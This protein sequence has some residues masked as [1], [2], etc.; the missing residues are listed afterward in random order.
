MIRPVFVIRN[1]WQGE[2][3][4]LPC[5]EAA[6]EHDPGVCRI[7]DGARGRLQ[8]EAEESRPSRQALM[9]PLRG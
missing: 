2:P 4:Q 6:I 1:R 7:C 9:V 3:W 5:H 8:I